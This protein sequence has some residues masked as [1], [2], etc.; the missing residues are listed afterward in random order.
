MNKAVSSVFLPVTIVL[1]LAAGYSAAEDPPFPDYRA[2]GHGT[3]AVDRG[4]S[5]K[6]NV[7]CRMA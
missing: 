3:M 1:F 6:P 4:D 2:D 5:Y 7:W